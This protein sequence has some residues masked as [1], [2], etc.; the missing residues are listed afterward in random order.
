MHKSFMVLRMLSG[1]EVGL[2]GYE[3][4]ELS[5]GWLSGGTL[6]VLLSRM[7]SAGLLE[8]EVLER[9]GGQGR[10]KRRYWLTDAGFDRLW[11]Y[12]EELSWYVG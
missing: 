9:D 4:V 6:Y 10:P 12:E 1:S 2:C 8:S 7:E 3:M 11:E 5:G